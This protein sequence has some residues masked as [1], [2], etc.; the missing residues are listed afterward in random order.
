MSAQP[1]RNTAPELA[2]LA[3]ALAELEPRLPG[4]NHGWLRA[5]RRAALERLLGGGLP[6]PRDDEW[7]YTDLRALGRRVRAPAPGPGPV[8]EDAVRALAF[9]GLAVHRIVL[10]D[11]HLVP[12]L[13]AVGPLPEGAS[14]TGLAEALA[15]G[16]EG[17]EA[18]LALAEGADGFE[19]LNLAFL[20][21]GFWLRLGENVVLD[22]PVHLIHLRS[23]ATDATACVRHLLELGPG[24][25]A[26]VIETYAALGPAEALDDVVREVRLA[27]GAALEHLVVRESSRALLHVGRSRV[28]QAAGSRY[29]SH[30]V[31]LGGRA[32]RSAI[33]VGLDGEGAECALHG[34]Y[35]L[36]GRE[37]ADHW[38]RIEHR[39][40][41]AVSRELYKGVLDGHARGAFTGRVVVRPGAQRTDAEQAN[42]NLL[43]SEDAEADSRPQLEIYA[44]DV[45]C[46]H[47]STVGEL[48]ETALFY[49][50]S[51]A[52][53]EALARSLLVYAFAS[54]VLERVGL[55]PVRVQLERR[56]TARLLRGQ[57]AEGVI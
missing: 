56:L 4:A 55:E 20:T 39:S 47:G 36:T 35:V 48:D 15:N 22:R 30:D 52:I 3:A 38:T 34:L 43:L 10:V 14:L 42:H 11:G 31:T 32:T 12:G 25:R 50:R 49:L 8:A 18:R 40:P 33:E 54:D 37:R 17:L 2:P 44:D 9:E 21:D 26:T 29:G 45:K 5:A 41:G 57:E 24:A 16:A 13:C 7:R 19:A 23:G 28:A 6:D 46:S 51:R 27:D 1:E 53:G